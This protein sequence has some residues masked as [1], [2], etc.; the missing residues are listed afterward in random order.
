[1]ARGA[2]C[3]RPH[4]EIAQT[5][6]WRAQP[7]NRVQR[8][9]Y[10]GRPAGSL[11]REPLT[12]RV[13]RRKNGMPMTITDD[14][15]QWALDQFKWSL[16]ALA[17]PADSQPGLFPPFVVVADEL[18]LDFEQSHG[19]ISA[20]L[21]DSWSHSQREAVSALDKALLDMSGPDKPQFWTDE[22]CLHH[23]RWEEIRRLA[24]AALSAFAWPTEP[25]PN[26]RAVYV[27]SPT[28]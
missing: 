5:R 4:G 10:V 27:G 11:L 22:G 19:V 18:A 24:C 15:L 12:R 23:P 8:T 26:N 9:R 3:P 7:N 25:P 17:L 2:R 21:R 6:L 13:R 28:K 16:Q 1:M 20:Q 14:R